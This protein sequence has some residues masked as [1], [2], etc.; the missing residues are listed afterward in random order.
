[1]AT[2]T[3][4]VVIVQGHLDPQHRHFCHALADTYAASFV[5]PDAKPDERMGS[6]RTFRSGKH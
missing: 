2:G 3:R 6:R 4:H 5:F 1:M